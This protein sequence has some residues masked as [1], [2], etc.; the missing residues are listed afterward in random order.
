M[1]AL[2]PWSKKQAASYL[3]SDSRINFLE[4]SVRSGKTIASLFRW[5]KYATVEHPDGNLLMVGKTMNTLY[6]NA[7]MPLKDIVGAN[8]CI[9]Y[10]GRKV[11]YLCGREILL[12]GATDKIAEQ[13]IR[14]LTLAG[15]YCD[16][17][18]LYDESFWTMLL[19][20][21][22]IPGA[23][24]FATANP[25]SPYHYLK[26]KFL[27]RMDELDLRRFSFV[28]SDNPS[29]DP[30]YVD[31]LKREYTGLFYK[32]LILGMW[33]MAQGAI[34][35][36][37]SEANEVE[38]EEIE[39]LL[40]HDEYVAID[41][42]TTNPCAFLLCGVKHGHEPEAVVLEEYYWDSAKE[43]RQKT[44]QQY[45]DD[46]AEFI[47]RRQVKGIIV[48]PS[49]ASFILELRQR[50]FPV[51][52]ADNAV[53]DGIRLTASWIASGR[54]KVSK[55]CVNLIREI[56]SYVWDEKAQL[57]GEDAPLKKNDH[58]CDALR[59]FAMKVLR[60]IGA[61]IVMGGRRIS[62]GSTIRVGRDR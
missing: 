30:A 62:A 26:V 48:D 18:T 35:D 28:L 42:G 60:S 14:G 10:G 13:K 12:E 27:D 25:D 46:L 17:A 32:R 39:K 45:A 37:W 6:R 47:G 29:L 15:A 23:K 61:Q 55:K 3:Y 16:E 19:S 21:L 8:N 57:R 22:S 51:I 56:E 24:L 53:V 1:F 40:W 59:Y 7:I 2:Q 36:A 41:Y 58:A 11:L 38:P 34:Y 43:G 49:A 31:Q 50:G 44:D 52:P 20:R 5:I 33:V 9:Y 4:G 54:L